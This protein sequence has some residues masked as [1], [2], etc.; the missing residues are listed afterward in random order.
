VAYAEI[1]KCGDVV[2]VHSTMAHADYQSLGVMKFLF[3]E[4]MK[5]YPSTTFFYGTSDFLHK[6]QG[7]FQKDLGITNVYKGEPLIKRT[8]V[9]DFDDLECGKPGLEEV[10]KL[11]E[12]FPN[13][14]VT[15][16]MVPMPMGLLKGELSTSKYREWA[17]F[18][19]ENQDWIEICPH[20]FTHSGFEMRNY[21][22]KTGKIKVVD[23]KT[24][25]LM[26]DSAEKMFKELNL[27]FKKIWKSPFWESSQDT[28]RALWNRGYTV[29]CDP[30]QPIPIGGDV[31]LFNW[32]I[33]KPMPKLPIVYGHGHLY[34][35]SANAIQFAMSNLLAMPEDAEFKFVSETL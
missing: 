28:I 11:K 35:P 24:A 33:E 26:I 20:G 21:Q 27:P 15:F 8:I 18:L 1:V 25:N 2:I 6:E 22:T 14:K 7:N 3:V 30:N 32:S 19:R 13:L 9:L 5:Y 31:Y 12:H 23:T 29:A 16:F 4:L 10:L 17:G 34:P